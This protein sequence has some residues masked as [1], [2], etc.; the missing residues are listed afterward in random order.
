VPY[1]LR[2]RSTSTLASAP[3]CRRIA[4]VFPGPAAAAFSDAQEVGSSI[5]LRGNCA[6]QAV[7][8]LTRSVCRLFGF[9]E[10]RVTDEL[11]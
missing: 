5:L 11:A 8:V 9:D 3:S 1:R 4:W 7:V 6:A 2:G 10:L